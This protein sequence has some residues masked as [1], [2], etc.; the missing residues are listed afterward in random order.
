MSSN[1]GEYPP[2]SD[3]DLAQEQI[4]DENLGT[5]QETLTSQDDVIR[6]I[7]CPLVE[8]CIK[9]AEE[10]APANDLGSVSAYT[11]YAENI[12]EV[13]TGPIELPSHIP[14]KHP[15]RMC[16]SP[17]VKILPKRLRRGR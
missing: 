13:C 5:M 9:K 17:K 6:C 12:Q 10:H 16:N 4:V 7:G 14:F 1:S 8:K 3:P 11:R 2:Q 15:K